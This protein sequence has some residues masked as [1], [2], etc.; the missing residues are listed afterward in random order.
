[1]AE[2]KPVP[3]AFPPLPFPDPFPPKPV[4]PDWDPVPEP[5]QTQLMDQIRRI[6]NRGQSLTMGEVATLSELL[7]A[8]SVNV[9]F[10]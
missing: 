1:M 5:M 10:P 9:H 6:A 4:H 7:L 2:G 8:V 3:E